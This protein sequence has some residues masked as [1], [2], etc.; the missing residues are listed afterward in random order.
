MPIVICIHDNYIHYLYSTCLFSLPL[1]LPVYV[2]PPLAYTH[3]YIRGY[4]SNKTIYAR[5]KYDRLEAFF[6]WT[7]LRELR[8]SRPWTF[9]Y[10][11]GELSCPNLRVPGILIGPNQSKPIAPKCA[12]ETAITAIPDVPRPPTPREIAR[13]DLSNDLIRERKPKDA[14]MSLYILHTRII[15]VINFV[16]TNVNTNFHGELIVVDFAHVIIIT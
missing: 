16:P 9:L 12:R 10:F 4:I 13:G 2:P 5:T 6:R 7:L 8:Y 14:R 3:I 15:L 11:R 1:S